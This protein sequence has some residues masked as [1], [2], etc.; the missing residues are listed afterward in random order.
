MPPPTTY[1][2]SP[3]GASIG[4]GLHDAS[5]SSDNVFYFIDAQIIGWDPNV[6]FGGPAAAITVEGYMDST[7]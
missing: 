1:P 2:S 5:M 6:G 7:L 3:N 4:D